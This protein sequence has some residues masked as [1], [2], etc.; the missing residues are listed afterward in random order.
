[1]AKVLIPWGFNLADYTIWSIEVFKLLYELILLMLDAAGRIPLL[2]GAV[3]WPLG[4][5]RTWRPRERRT[6]WSLR[7]LWSNR[8]RD[9]SS[10]LKNARMLRLTQ[11]ILRL[12]LSWL[13]WLQLLRLCLLTFLPL[14]FVTS[15]WTVKWLVNIY[16]VRVIRV[17][18]VAQKFKAIIVGRRSLLLIV[19]LR[20]YFT[21]S[22]S[23]SRHLASAKMLGAVGPRSL[24]WRRHARQMVREIVLQVLV[25]L[26]KLPLPIL[27]LLGWVVHVLSP[28]SRLALF[29]W[30]VGT[31]LSGTSRFCTVAILTW[32]TFMLLLQVYWWFWNY[33][34]LNLSCGRFDLVNVLFK[35]IR[36]LRRVLLLLKPTLLTRVLT[37]FVQ[38]RLWLALGGSQLRVQIFIIFVGMLGD[39][40]WF[41]CV[42]SGLVG[43]LS[44]C[45]GG[46]FMVWIVTII[47]LSI[48][49]AATLDMRLSSLNFVCGK[50]FKVSNARL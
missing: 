3:H 18:G 33:A 10:A 14:V 15:S 31:L 38:T 4:L 9:K 13:F 34:I 17:G 1:M 19:V 43:W 23:C 44:R 32:T 41:P 11:P 46:C 22:T 20:N 37:F 7:L 29:S 26:I 30:R 35:S 6:V 5:F 16:L 40:R 8:H 24:L 48:A 28:W 42:V 39:S 50:L 12:C 36:N 27:V 21:D 45:K 47:D 2:W 25:L 49:A